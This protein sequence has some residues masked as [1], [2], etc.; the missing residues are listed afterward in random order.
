MNVVF[1]T[2]VAVGIAVLLT[3]TQI[4]V[5]AARTGSIIRICFLAFFVGIIFH[6]ILDYIPHCYPV[7]SKADVIISLLI[8]SLF[9]WLIDKTYR[10]I[11]FSAFIGSIFPD[12]I[13]LSTGILNKLLSLNLPVLNKFFP[14]HWSQYSGSIYNGDCNV[15]SLNHLMIIFTVI[16]ILYYK[17]FDLSKMRNKRF[18]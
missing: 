8:I 10:W 12:L 17:R 6:G 14:W 11:L 7:N 15:S 4:Q 3:D 1:H 18:K 5:K 2:S 16:V 13:D 9:L